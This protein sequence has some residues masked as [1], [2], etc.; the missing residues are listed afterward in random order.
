MHGWMEGGKEGAGMREGGA[1]T[2]D[3]LVLQ[4]WKQI[5]RVYQLHLI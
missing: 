2:H 5:E 1:H 3:T 4:K